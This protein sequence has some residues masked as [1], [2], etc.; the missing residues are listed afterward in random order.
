MYYQEQFYLFP[1]HIF[2]IEGYQISS[3]VLISFSQYHIFVIKG[4][5]ISS[6]YCID[7]VFSI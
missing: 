6:I 2:V 3:I 1:Y 5:Q 4:Y 7:F